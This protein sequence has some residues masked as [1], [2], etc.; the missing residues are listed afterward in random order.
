MIA[1]HPTILLSM[2]TRPEIIKMAPIY[3]ELKA[4]GVKPLLLHT[5]QHNEVA[6]SLYEL[7]GMEPDYYIDLKR[8]IAP[9]NDNTQ[10]KGNDLAELGSKLLLECSQILTKVRPSM[11]LVHGD[12]SSAVMMAMAAYYQKCKIA[13]IEAGLRSHDEYHPFPE[14][15]NRVIIGQL[16][17]WHFAP[18][19]RARNNLVAEGIHDRSIHVVGNTVVQA[20]QLGAERLEEQRRKIPSS[21]EDLICKLSKKCVGKRM[22]LVT[23][24]RRE[25][26]KKGICEIAAGVLQLLAIH[27]DMVIVWPVHPNPKVMAIIKD[28]IGNIS[29]E[30]AERLYLTKPLSYPVLLWVLKHSW[31]VLTDSG[32]IQ[33]EAA[34]LG[35]P[36]LVLRQTTERPELIEAGAGA[37]VGANS[38]RILGAVETLSNNPNQYAAMKNA[39][40]PFGDMTVAHTICN[41]LLGADHA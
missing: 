7:F 6:T 11:V 37:L 17:Q 32:G 24:H 12:T 2:G 19:Q 34:A 8:D 20:T 21:V 25:N 29:G 10:H 40:N 3:L 18:T 31:V 22:V 23:T 15:K 36:V 14:E 30:L 1:T 27:K 13:H 4:R 35:T 39:T 33:E 28:K 16:A 38:D 9:A 26:L 5:G 41:I